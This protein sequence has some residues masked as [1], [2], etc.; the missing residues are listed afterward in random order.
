MA[1]DP[2]TDWTTNWLQAQH[3]YWDAWQQLSKLGSPQPEPRK[4]PWSEALDQWWKAVSPAAPDPVQ[5]FYNQLVEQG[6][7]FMRTSETLRHSLMPDAAVPPN[8]WATAVEGSLNALRD[9]FAQGA[10]GKDKDGREALHQMFSFWELPVD[11][12]QRCASVLCGFPGDA[13]GAFKP[14]SDPG[15]GTEMFQEHVERFLSAPGLGY[16]REHQEQHQTFMRALMAYQAALQEYNEQFTKIAMNSV[17]RFRETLLAKGGGDD[18]ITTLRGLYDLWVDVCEEVYAEQVFTEEYSAAHGKLV[19][20]LMAVKLQGRTMVDE[21][22][23]TLG[24]PTR[25][26]VDS[27]EKRV[28]QLRREIH[29]RAPAAAPAQAPAASPSPPPRAEAPPAA[30]RATAPKRAA[31]K[32]KAAPRKRRATTTKGASK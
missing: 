7:Q 11:T 23:G 21:A 3:R 22:V 15:D 4:D 31:V 10:Q 16:T 2:I 6:K 24:L 32:K 13:L 17:D 20:A 12:W 5:G 19:N 29:A 9:L 28:Q 18:T 30:A 26:E 27:I 8:Q 25:R 1:D 14:G